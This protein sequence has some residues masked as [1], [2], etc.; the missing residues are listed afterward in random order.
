MFQPY[1][2]TGQPAGPLRAPA[3]APVL[4]A[5]R[6]VY[7]GAAIT[8][9]GARERWMAVYP[10]VPRDRLRQAIFHSATIRGRE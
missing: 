5:V 3:P 1:S 7:G 4:T 6:F 9:S 8:A 10:R 2:S